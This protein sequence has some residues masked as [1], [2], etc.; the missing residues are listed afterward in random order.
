MRAAEIFWLEGTVFS[1]APGFN[2][3]RD[4]VYPPTDVGPLGW[5]FPPGSLIVAWPKCLRMLPRPI[6][7]IIHDASVRPAVNGWLREGVASATIT[8]SRKIVSATADDSSVT[9]RLDDGSTRI[10]DHVLLG[11][12]YR[13]DISRYRFL[14][15]ELVNSIACVDGYPKLDFGFESSVGGLYF[16]GAAASRSFGP[17]MRF[18]A[19]TEYSARTIARRIAAQPRIQS[20]GGRSAEKR[21]SS[22]RAVQP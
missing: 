16:T 14:A 17:L 5:H 12:G 22:S 6:Q 13:V 10:V 11:T 8:A 19:G 7:Q 18:V 1:R 2:A 20:S 15:P 4:I 9:L 21:R 3:L